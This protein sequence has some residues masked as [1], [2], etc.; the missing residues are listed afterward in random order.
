MNNYIES[1]AV[2]N[3]EWR[4]SFLYQCL[5]TKKPFDEKEFEQTEFVFSKA[6][7]DFIVEILEKS[8]EFKALIDKYLPKDWSQ[9]RINWLE[10]S[11]MINAVAEIFIA[12]NIPSV[13]IAESVEYAKEYC[14]SDSYKIIHFTIDNIIKGEGK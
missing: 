7:K 14:D 11:I 4:I 1:A 13:V 2:Q 8:E 3:R 9:D 10:L 5:V 6:Q 12:N